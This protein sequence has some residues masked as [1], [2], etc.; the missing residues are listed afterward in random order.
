[1]ADRKITDLTALAAGSQA[2]GDLLTIVDVSESA[3]A[4]KNKKITI[5]NLL[6]GIPSN[7][8]IGT[9]SPSDK[10]SIAGSVSGEFRA[11]TLRNSSGST[12]STA[13]LTFEASAGTEGDTA[14]IAAQIK[15]VR[16][17][18]GTNGGLQFWTA[19]GGTPAERIRIDSS[20]RLLLGTTTAGNASAD[21]LTIANSGAAG[22]T[23]RSG[24]STAAAIYFADGTSGSQN[25]Q[26]IIQYNHTLDQLQFYANYAADSNPRMRIDSSGNV[27]L[28][29]APKSMHANVTSSLNVGS[30]GLFQRTKNTFISSNF[31]YNS[32]DVGKSIA[33]GHALIY[34][35]DVT[36]GAH[37]WFRT[38]SAS[39]ADETVSNV[40]SMRIDSSG[41]VGI[42]GAPTVFG[43]QNFLTIHSPGAS[44]NI[45]GVDFKV[46][47]TRE[48]S[49]IS[50]PSNSEALRIAG[51][52]NR[53]VTFH[54]NDTERMRIDSSGR[55]LVGTSS[56]S[57][58]AAAVVRAN[59]ANAAGAGV[60]DISRGTSRPSGSGTA[61]GYLRFTTESN[62]SNNYNYASIVAMSDGASSSNSDIKGR[63]E[64]HTTANGTGS[65][66]ERMRITSNGETRVFS[67]GNGIRSHNSSAASTS[68]N[69]FLGYHSASSTSNGTNSFR[70][71]TNGN[72]VN[73][74]NSYG[75][76]SDAKLKENIVDASSQWDDIKDLRVRN[77]N[78]IEGQTHTQIGV[79][80]QEVETVSP[81]LV[82]ESPDLDEEGNDLGTVTKSVNY[83]VLYMKAVKALQEAM[84]RIETLETSNA[85]LLAR[86]TA[87]EAG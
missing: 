18:G 79:V 43:G 68:A 7:V 44:T 77:Y 81:G 55:L 63:L 20:G 49:I 54:T 74:N 14:A 5:E 27:G 4:D 31:Y 25:Y 85:D 42:G 23:I 10:L 11:L 66:T 62:T 61:I 73:T 2:T 1:M 83:S 6:K 40:E 21:D 36:N 75:A 52:T 72:V 29:F 67:S 53:P 69:L 17:G 87:L 56:E 22:I 57:G 30:S 58:N 70:V 8:G 80:A 35:Q 48:A 9:T 76:I 37:I 84:T 47:G 12:N 19:N 33:S 65:P 78:F 38:G 16:L 39:G 3:A 71:Y 86:V 64:F 41:N 28:D 60:L 51:I 59:S 50:Y 24:S 32:S 45:A 34:Q 82:T 13:S 26:G 46:S 15:G